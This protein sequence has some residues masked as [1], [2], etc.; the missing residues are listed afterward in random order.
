MMARDAVEISGERTARRIVVQIFN[1]YERHKD[2]LRNIL[3]D[4]S[5]A[6]HLQRVAINARLPAFVKRDKRSFVADQRAPQQFIIG[7][8]FGNH[9]RRFSR[10]EARAYIELTQLIRPARTKSSRKF[11]RQGNKLNFL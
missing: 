9:H 1:S 8:V 6:A 5:G 11:R 10:N 4:Y 2:F 3:R 7:N